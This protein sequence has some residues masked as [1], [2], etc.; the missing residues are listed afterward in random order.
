MYNQAHVSPSYREVVVEETLDV[1]GG[2][3]APDYTFRIG[4]ERKFF[5]EAKRPGVD[6]KNAAAAA[7][8]LRRYAWTAKLPLSILTDFEELAVYDC[9]TRPADDDKAS[10]ARIRFLRFDEYVDNW[11]DVWYLFSRDCPVTG[12]A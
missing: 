5:A 2:R 12:S 10:T 1:E 8:Q 9:R 6:L 7:Y 3:K 4:R 11:R